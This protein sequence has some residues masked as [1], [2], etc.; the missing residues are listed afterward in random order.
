[1]K[2]ARFARGNAIFERWP[3]PI[4]RS[5]TDASKGSD[6][7]SLDRFSLK[8]PP[9]R[10]RERIED[11]SRTRRSVHRDTKILSGAQKRIGSSDEEPAV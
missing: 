11:A 8:Q 10:S 4:S 9:M 7:E 1:M 6:E 5:T 2:T 3:D